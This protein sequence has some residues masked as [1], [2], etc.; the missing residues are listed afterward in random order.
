M[1][2]PNVSEEDAKQLF[3]LHRTVEV[4]SGKGYIRVTP[5]PQ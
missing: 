4:P 2:L 3:P 5:Q 1:V